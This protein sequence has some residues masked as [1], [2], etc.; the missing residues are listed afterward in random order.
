MSIVDP[1][2]TFVVP[3]RATPYPSPTEG[4]ALIRMLTYGVPSRATP[5]L[6]VRHVKR[7]VHRG[8]VRGKGEC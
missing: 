5:Y 3:P 6:G 1:H 7:D 8:K 4:L 2:I